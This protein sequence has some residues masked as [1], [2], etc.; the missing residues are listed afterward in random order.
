MEKHP[1]NSRFFTELTELYGRAPPVVVT[2]G[3]SYGSIFTKL[4]I[5]QIVRRHSMR[6]HIERFLQE[7]KR[8]I[9]T[10]YTSF[11]GHDILLRTTG[12]GT[13]AGSGTL[14]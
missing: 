4:G 11:T 9:N 5:T 8:R 13:S 6:D 1:H 12:S 3:A 14:A 2:D 10:F 7:L